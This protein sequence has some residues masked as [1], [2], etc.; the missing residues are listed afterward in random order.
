[1]ELADIEWYGPYSYVKANAAR[2]TLTSGLPQYRF[3]DAFGPYESGVWGAHLTSNWFQD[4]PPGD[5]IPAL[6]DRLLEF[7]Y[8]PRDSDGSDPAG[9][10]RRSGW[11]LTGVRSRDNMG[12]VMRWS[13]SY[14][15]YDRRPTAVATETSNQFFYCEEFEVNFVDDEYAGISGTFIARDVVLGAFLPPNYRP[16]NYPQYNPCMDFN[17]QPCSAKDGTIFCGDEEYDPNVPNPPNVLDWYGP[18]SFL[19]MDDAQAK[20]DFEPDFSFRDF[21][22]R[23]PTYISDSFGGS[24]VR[25]PWEEF[26]Q[27][28]SQLY[29][30]SLSVSFEPLV[31]VSPYTLEENAQRFGY[32]ITRVEMMTEAGR[33]VEWEDERSNMVV[34]AAEGYH[35]YECE[36]VEFDFPDGSQFT[37]EYTEIGGYLGIDYGFGQLEGYNPCPYHDLPGTCRAANGIVFCGG[38]AVGDETE[39][40]P[41]A[42]PTR[43]PSAS[44]SAAPTAEPTEDRGDGPDIIWAGSGAYMSGKNVEG[45]L[46]L[47][48]DYTF[49]DDPGTTGR[50]DTGGTGAFLERSWVEDGRN[51]AMY[52]RAYPR[53]GGTTNKPFTLSEVK[54][55]DSNGN[56]LWWLNDVNQ[57]YDNR[58]VEN[59]IVIPAFHDGFFC[60]YAEFTMRTYNGNGQ[61]MGKFVAYDFTYGNF[62]GAG[63][64]AG[65]DCKLFN[66]CDELPNKASYG[67]RDGQR[68]RCAVI[69]AELTCNDRSVKFDALY[70]GVFNIQPDRQNGRTRSAAE[71]LTRGRTSRSVA[72]V[73]TLIAVV[74]GALL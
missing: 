26:H 22:D 59:P 12:R 28:E 24:I 23:P 62:L 20:V 68:C 5:V 18:R 43:S 36:R 56:Y 4:G 70:R 74:G 54:M 39:G 67:C 31:T 2:L 61:E 60:D 19:H 57:F 15:P 10:A 63:S 50:I 52:F 46:V 42:F 51:R 9:D 73:A 58:K 13:E 44:P 30:R 47:G 49:E 8:T 33:L 66:P 16:T 29:R 14:M 48:T 3:I 17:G 25:R 64:C 35:F 34:R 27:G 72:F 38:V 7:S 11:T 53:D 32:R 6:M 55:M 45:T 41:V 37:G 40:P 65:F 1:M 71:G 69:D 21:L